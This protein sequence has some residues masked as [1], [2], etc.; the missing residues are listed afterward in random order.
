MYYVI[1][2]APGMEEKTEIFIQKMIPD[3]LYT[4][5]F[6]L[7][8]RRRKKFHGQWKD[9][10]EKLLPGYVFI[11]SE[12]I[13]ALYL[14]LKKVPV[15][16]KMLGKEDVRFTPLTNKDIEWLMRLTDNGVPARDSTHKIGEIRAEIGLSQ[17]SVSAKDEIVII[18]G[19]LKGMEGMVKKIN[20]HKRIAEVE[21]DFMNRKTIIYLGIE[22]IENKEACSD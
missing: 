3:E 13:I 16:T 2:T 17:I 14:E 4:Q 18:S 11:I 15:L 12:D 7:T 10:L 8:R 1:Q 21:V 9:V 5:C 20:L 22:M 6:H 19:P